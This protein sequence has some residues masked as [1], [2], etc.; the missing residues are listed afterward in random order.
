MSPL[1]NNW[2]LP[3]KPVCPNVD[4]FAQSSPWRFCLLF[5]FRVAH[6]PRWPW[7]TPIAR[8]PNPTENIS[9]SDRQFIAYLQQSLKQLNE[10]PSQSPGS[11][12]S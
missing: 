1:I 3:R 6:Q 12:S 7:N 10:K 5:S 9:A 8:D 11:A 2:L 4:V